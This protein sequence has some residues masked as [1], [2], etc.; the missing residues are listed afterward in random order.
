LRNDLSWFTHL[1]LGESAKLPLRLYAGLDYGRV[2]NRVPGVPQGSLAGMALG[3]TI[4]F[5][6]ATL[7]FSATRAISL[8]VFMTKEATQYWLTLRFNF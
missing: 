1:P 6:G 5:P 8:P 4:N 3:A 2:R 7:D